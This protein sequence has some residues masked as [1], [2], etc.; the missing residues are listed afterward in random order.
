MYKPLELNNKHGDKFID[1]WVSILSSKYYQNNVAITRFYDE[2]SF[3]YP[4][5]NPRVIL[6][7]IKEQIR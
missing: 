1:R 4:T 3:E 6:G 7:Y 5:V 2:V